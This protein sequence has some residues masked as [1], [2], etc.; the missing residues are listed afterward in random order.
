M[1]FYLRIYNDKQLDKAGENEP[2]VGGLNYDV[3]EGTWR[4]NVIDLCHIMPIVYYLVELLINKI[5]FPKR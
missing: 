5:K 3:L 4:V 1:V 2:W